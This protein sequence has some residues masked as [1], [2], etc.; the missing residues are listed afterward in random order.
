MEWS[1]EKDIR[2]FIVDWL[3]PEKELAKKIVPL[4]RELRHKKQ[5]AW[6]AI[7]QDCQELLAHCG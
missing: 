7:E 2:L 4:Y 1:T 6:V 3:L 5:D